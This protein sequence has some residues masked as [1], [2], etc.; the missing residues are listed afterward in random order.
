M[1]LQGRC[2]KCGGKLLLTVTEGSI[3]KYLDIAI[4]ICDKYDAAPYIKQRLQL[5]KIEI[6]S[7]FKNDRARQ[8]GL[9]DFM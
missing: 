4:S 8:T 1:P 2:A 9:A 5:L 7:L 6:D 3:R